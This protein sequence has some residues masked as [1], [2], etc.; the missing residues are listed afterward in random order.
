MWNRNIYQGH[1]LDLSMEFVMRTSLRIVGVKVQVRRVNFVVFSSKLF[2]LFYFC[3]VASYL[4]STILY[5]YLA[6]FC[7]GCVVIWAMYYSLM[8]LCLR[9]VDK[10]HL[11]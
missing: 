6:T 9:Y 3:S 11:Y 1:G 10:F 4:S 2:I 7:A 5:Y 8:V